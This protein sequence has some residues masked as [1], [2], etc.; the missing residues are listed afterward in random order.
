MAD[1]GHGENCVNENHTKTA[2][3]LAEDVK[4]RAEELKEKANDFFKSKKVLLYIVT[5]R[6]N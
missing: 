3:D 1:T 4:S 5:G 6:S 2:D